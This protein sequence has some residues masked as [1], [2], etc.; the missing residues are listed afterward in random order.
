MTCT[1]RLAIMHSYLDRV[2]T[3]TMN[4]T[5]IET[6]SYVVFDVLEAL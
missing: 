4:L 2:V 5:F 6:S 1:Y 3:S